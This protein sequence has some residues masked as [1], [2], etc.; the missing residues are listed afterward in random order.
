IQQKILL[1]FV[2]LIYLPF[3]TWRLGLIMLFLSPGSSPGQAWLTVL[4]SGFLR[5]PPHSDSLA[6]G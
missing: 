2:Q 5:T 4:H 1:I 3:L 6:F